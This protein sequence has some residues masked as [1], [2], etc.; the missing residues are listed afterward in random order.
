M[1]AFNAGAVTEDRPYNNALLI[2]E[3][4]DQRNL[5]IASGIDPGHIE[6][7][8]VTRLETIQ[9]ALEIRE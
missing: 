7:D 6:N 5:S 9:H 3:L 4:N 1:C 2:R 8:W